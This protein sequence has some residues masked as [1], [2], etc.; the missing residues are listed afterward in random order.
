LHSKLLASIRYRGEGEV[1]GNDVKLG[2]KPWLT[3]NATPL[4]SLSLR[5]SYRSFHLPA[6]RAL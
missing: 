1:R 6:S 5:Y 3:T 2:G 4:K